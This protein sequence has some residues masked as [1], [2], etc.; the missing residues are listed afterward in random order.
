MAQSTRLICIALASLALTS[1]AALKPNAGYMVPPAILS[2]ATTEVVIGGFDLTPD[3]EI[4][5]HS[6]NIV[7]NKLPGLGKFLVARPPYWFG[8]KGRSTAFP[9]PREIRARITVP[10]G[11]PSGPAFYQLTNANG[12]SA[13]V[14]FHITSQRD[15]M[16]L[17]DRDLPQDVQLPLTIAGRISLISE[18]DKYRFVAR[19]DGL[20]SAELFARRIGSNFNGLVTVKDAAGRTLTDSADTQGIDT[21][22]TFAVKAGRQYEVQVADIDF[23]GNVAFVYRLK[24]THGPRVI[25]TL[26]AV[27]QRGVKNDVEVIGIGL[28][29]GSARLE[30]V[31]Q[32]ILVPKSVSST[33][34]L[35]LKTPGGIANARLPI[36]DRV[37]RVAKATQ[38]P[39]EL[40]LPATVSSRLGVQRG[41]RYSLTAKK[42]TQL[43]IAVQ[44]F[45]FGSSLD[46]I[47]YVLD[48]KGKRLAKNDDVTNTDSRLLFQV[49]S[50]GKYTIEVQ[51]QSGR[52]PGLMDVYRLTVDTPAAGF[53]V[54]AAQSHVLPVGGKAVVK[55][56]LQRWGG[57]SGPVKFRI[58]GLP[59]GIKADLA[60]AEI[61]K[62]TA[63]TIP[64]QIDKAA[65]TKAATI[66][67]I[68]TATI[69]GKT[70]ERV[71]R[72]PVGGNL[73]PRMQPDRIPAAVV[74]VTMPAPFK[75]KVIDRNRQR[76]V[77]RGTTY[78][79]ELIIERNKGFNGDVHL[80]RIANQSR[81]RQGINGP[82]VKVAAGQ[83]KAIYPCFMPEWLETDRTTRLRLMGMAAV[84][85]AKGNLRF[86]TLNADAAITMILEGALLKVSH[87]AKEL[88]VKPGTTFSIPVSIA[89]S[90]KLQT[91]VNISLEV[92]TALRG[93]LQATAILIPVKSN[94]GVLRI[95]TTATTRLTAMWQLTIRA[96][97]KIDGKW[98]VVSQTTVPVLFRR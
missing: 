12:T 19:Q 40:A 41:Q 91:K 1:H 28:R 15:V 82:I 6:P 64:L 44:S 20:V 85:D 51:D 81:H 31:R 43:R 83:T 8:P 89:R 76:P 23:R 98:L 50:D 95:K 11:T 79:A 66:R 27:L 70:V 88:T 84:A 78:V 34:Q 65:S 56:K 33:Y 68:G 10:K 39:I 55:L 42:G 69:N 48:A 3:I 5:S 17:R 29:T 7:I 74:Q 52:R 57:F 26:P 58:E 22:V 30:S 4:I 54:V 60:K 18:V 38:K 36:S 46:V 62:G 96:T 2:G 73:C 21:A 25:A 47:V 9:L 97:T 59:A 49:P 37:E 35:Q 80:L 92:P 77:H 67:I 14:R 24:M 45:R 13:I 87:Q 75:V 72:Y 86:L 93:S 94:R 63:G 90:P 32:S 71:A 53:D 61:K 16:E